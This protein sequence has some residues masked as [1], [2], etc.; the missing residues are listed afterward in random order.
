MRPCFI[1]GGA[2]NALPVL[3]PTRSSLDD[4][5]SA[6]DLPEET[7]SG[8]AAYH[9]RGNAVSSVLRLYYK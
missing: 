3:S 6:H 5:D 8:V 1:Q 7:S 2:C 4:F 9:V